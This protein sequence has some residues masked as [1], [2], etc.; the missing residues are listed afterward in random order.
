MEYGNFKKFHLWEEE[1]GHWG[2][3]KGGDLGWVLEDEFCGEKFFFSP[4]DTAQAWL[5][6]RFVEGVENGKVLEGDRDEILEFLVG[7]M[8]ELGFYPSFIK[9][10]HQRIWTVV[11]ECELTLSKLNMYIFPSFG[12]QSSFFYRTE[13]TINKSFWED[14][15]E[16]LGLGIG[17]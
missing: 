17:G 1:W 5:E 4:R 6:M 7:Y 12:V 16:G 13:H 11:G 9:T 15:V 3:C 8:Q 14:I 10:A 2:T